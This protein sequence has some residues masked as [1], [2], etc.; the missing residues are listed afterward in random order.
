MVISG[1]PA[2]L[3]NEMSGVARAVYLQT[4]YAVTGAAVEA[5]RWKYQT[6][7]S[8]WK[9]KMLGPIHSR[10]G[11]TCDKAWIIIASGVGRWRHPDIPRLPAVQRR[12]VPVKR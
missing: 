11:C 9:G 1:G 6:E 12:C 7:S 3:S 2:K 4:E 5:L 8:V 10:P